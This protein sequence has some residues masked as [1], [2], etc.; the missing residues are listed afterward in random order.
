MRLRT[1]A[2]AAS[3]AALVLVAGPAAAAPGTAARTFGGAPLDDVL[4]RAAQERRCGLTTNELAAMMLAPTY[5]ETGAP[6]DQ[7]PSPMTLSRWDD[8]PGLH[9]FGTVAG[10]PRAFWHPGVGMWQ[11]DSAGL[12]ARFTAAQLVDT[13]FVAA[14]TAATIVDRWCAKPNLANAWAPW[15][16]CADGSCKTTFRATYRRTGDRLV[17]VGRDPDVLRRGGMTRHTCTGP[18]RTGPFTCWR[19]D[20]AR[21][22]GYAGFTAPGF[23]PAPVSAPFYVYAAGRFEYRHWLRVDTGHRRAVWAQR[24]LGANARTSLT[25][26]RGEPLTVL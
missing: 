17:G 7:A 12:G 5:P 16:G 22:Q 25:W 3:V 15:H 4:H 9:S 8:Q 21:A 23:G 24:P 6:R 10:Q 19:I 20:P 26:H 13:N 18:G 1:F 2:V 11:F 14:R